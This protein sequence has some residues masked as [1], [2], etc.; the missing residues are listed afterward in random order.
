MLKT[1]TEELNKIYEKVINEL[2]CNGFTFYR[3]YADEYI[4]DIGI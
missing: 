4:S 1:N 3:D 2:E